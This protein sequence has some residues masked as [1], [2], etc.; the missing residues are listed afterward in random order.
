MVRPRERAARVRAVGRGSTHTYLPTYTSTSYASCGTDFRTY[1]MSQEDLAHG[2]QACPTDASS[3]GYPSSRR[4]AVEHSF[5][6]SL[7]DRQHVGCMLERGGSAAARAPVPVSLLKLEKTGGTSLAAT[8]VSSCVAYHCA[9]L[10]QAGGNL[11]CQLSFASYARACSRRLELNRVRRGMASEFK[12]W[13]TCNEPGL[14]K[15]ARGLS[16]LALAIRGCMRLPLLVNKATTDLFER[17]RSP[18]F[19][20]PKPLQWSAAPY[21]NLV[22]VLRE[23]VGRMLS[24]LYF[25]SAGG[26]LSERSLNLTAMGG[27]PLNTVGAAELTTRALRLDLLTQRH[28]FG[29]MPVAQLGGG[30]GP[31]AVERAVHL[32][33]HYGLV[34]LTEQ[35]TETRALLSLRLGLGAG[36]LVE[37]S[38]KCVGGG[39]HRSVSLL[40][41]AVRELLEQAFAPELELYRRG[42]EIHRAQ[43]AAHDSASFRAAVGRI[44]RE[45]AAFRAACAAGCGAA[46]RALL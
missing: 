30:E 43:V 35:P 12:A 18:C 13:E 29:P 1:W 32:L 9:V 19:V 44:E 40:R 23:P 38:R 42:V 46:A 15:E 25:F 27:R 6:A 39:A 28:V 3:G 17:R 37:C 4:F 34:G 45:Q 22:T 36:A 41:P 26:S 21:R 16:G 24:A 33:R 7:L 31:G 20:A 10:A 14:N 5:S 2:L 8:I 11:S